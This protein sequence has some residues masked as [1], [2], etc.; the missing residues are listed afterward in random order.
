MSS[1]L[2]RVTAKHLALQAWNL[3][4]TNGPPEWLDSQQTLQ[5]YRVRWQIELLFRLW[6]SQAKLSQVGR[7]RKARIIC[8]L[9]ARLIALVL[10]NWLAAPWRFSSSF[11]K[12]WR[13]F[14]RFV[15]LLLRLSPVTGGLYHDYFAKWL[16]TFYVLLSRT[17]VKSR[18]QLINYLFGPG[19]SLMRM[20]H[21]ARFM[22]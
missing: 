2:P 9:Y 4:I 7:Y 18:L 1:T 10:F 21:S 17:H 8:Q 13:V 15:D 19:L 11:P 5:L 16:T 20:G 14:Q 3:F 22:L 6:K 12:A